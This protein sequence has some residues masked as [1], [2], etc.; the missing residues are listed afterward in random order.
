MVVHPRPAVITLVVIAFTPLILTAFPT[1]EPSAAAA[2]V[3]E[4]RAP[5]RFFIEP[6]DLSVTV[7]VEPDPS[8]R[9]LRL[10][11][12][13]DGVFRASEIALDG[14]HAIRV[15]VVRFK[16]LPAGRYRLRAEVRSARSLRTAEAEVLVVGKEAIH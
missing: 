14:E 13:S 9:M 6:A 2:R 10:E 5:G 1:V 3:V 8:N 16:G 7:D 4:I 12:D 11:A 15:H